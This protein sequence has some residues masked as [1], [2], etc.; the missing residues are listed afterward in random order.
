[1]ALALECVLVAKFGFTM[2]QARAWVL[3]VTTDT[4]PGAPD[5]LD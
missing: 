1:M 3:E 2:G 4:T 5:F